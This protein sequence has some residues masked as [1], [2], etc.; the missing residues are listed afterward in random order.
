MDEGRPIFLQIAEQLENSII[1]GS[2]AE[3]AQVPSTNELAAF[4]RINPATAAKGVGKLADDGVIYKKR[5]IGMFVT[6]GARATLRNR[7]REEFRRAVRR[8]AARRGAQARARRRGRQS[9]DREGGSRAVS[10]AISV[11]G[12]SK[13]YGKVTAVDDVTFSIRENAI[14]GLLGRNGAGKTTLMQLLTGQVRA[15]SGEITI[16]DQPVYEND[17][18]LRD[19]CFIREAQR[20]PD[21]FRVRHALA[22]GRLLFQHWDEAFAQQLV[23]DFELPTGRAVKKLSRGMLSALGVIIGLASRAPLTLFDEPYLGLD[24]VARR[25]FYD[26]LLA[27]YVEHPR[28]IVL[29]THLIDEVSDLIEHVLLIDH[30]R[31]IL[32][33]DAEVLRGQMLTLSGPVAAIDDVV[34]NAGEVH[35][36][37]IGTM[38]RVT[39]RGPLVAADRARAS[40]IAVE[41]VSLQ[42]LIVSLTGRKEN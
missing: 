11:R 24:A 10:D 37:R 33:E 18:T 31:L 38:A 39:V 32:D 25:L 23:A 15:A 41:P 5:G 1:D 27:D 40:G 22:S 12:L 35:R 29:S 16:F 42:N 17:A 20:Y 36:E 28:T 30:G 4:H 7:R 8:A 26:R 3:E 34:A 2:L 21:A 9:A 6:L 19:I 13:R 14:Y